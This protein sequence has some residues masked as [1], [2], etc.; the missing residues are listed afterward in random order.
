[1]ETGVRLLCRSAV[2]GGVP[3]PCATSVHFWGWKKRCEVQGAP[4]CG[5]VLINYI[6]L[7]HRLAPRG[8]WWLPELRGVTGAGTAA[9]PGPVAATGTQMQQQRGCWVGRQRR[10]KVLGVSSPTAQRGLGPAGR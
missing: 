3:S 4:S 6:H 9:P 1:M 5:T 2:F 10:G 7:G 8:C